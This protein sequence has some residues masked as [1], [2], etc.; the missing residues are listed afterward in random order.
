MR[1]LHDFATNVTKL[2]ALRTA[3]IAPVWA[4]ATVSE[5]LERGQ[6]GATS[7]HSWRERERDTQHCNR[8]KNLQ[9]RLLTFGK[10][11]SCSRFT[12][13]HPRM[14]ANCW[15]NVLPGA[16]FEPGTSSMIRSAPL[17]TTPRGPRLFFS[18]SRSAQDR[19]QNSEKAERC[20]IARSI[21]C[22]KD[23]ENRLTESKVMEDVSKGN[24]QTD[25][26]TDGRT[27][28]TVLCRAVN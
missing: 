8:R 4:K 24:R 25:G 19:N 10:G 28:A 22:D 11:F 14:T 21:V 13:D 1:L 20:G 9:K 23:R 26:R 12:L 3:I 7:K 18:R 2:A 17:T 15:Q 6:F 5:S 16:G 27:D